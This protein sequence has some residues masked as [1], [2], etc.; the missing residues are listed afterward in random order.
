MVKVDYIEAEYDER[1]DKGFKK[2]AAAGYNGSKATGKKPGGDG[3]QGDAIGKVPKTSVKKRGNE[4]EGTG[5]G[6]DG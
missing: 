3:D 4:G 5:E 2:R 1:K 6:D